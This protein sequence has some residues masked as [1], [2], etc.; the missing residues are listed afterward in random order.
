MAIRYYLGNCKVVGGCLF[1]NLINSEMG[2]KEKLYGKI[3]KIEYTNTVRR[4]DTSNTL[5]E[6]Q[7][8]DMIDR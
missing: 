2:K 3:L 6:A 5:T 8:G 1:P 7:L 4:S